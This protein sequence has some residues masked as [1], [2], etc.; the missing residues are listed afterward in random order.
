MLARNNSRV[1]L[2]PCLVRPEQPDFF[3][4]VEH[5]NLYLFVISQAGLRHSELK[6]FRQS[7]SK[8]K[9]FA[10]GVQRAGD[11]EEMKKEQG[12]K[13]RLFQW[14]SIGWQLKQRSAKSK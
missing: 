12:R 3:S 14:S 9:A 13:G 8:S 4:T 6:A 11:M 7:T 2:L 5:S 1:W 10:Y